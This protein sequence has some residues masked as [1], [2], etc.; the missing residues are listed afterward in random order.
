MS[1]FDDSR[2]LHMFPNHA[3]NDNN[4]KHHDQKYSSN[5]KNHARVELVM[6]NPNDFC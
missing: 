4:N 6:I 3:C 2:D 5:N 1:F